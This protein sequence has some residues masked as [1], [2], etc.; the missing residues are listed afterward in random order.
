MFFGCE[1][2][3]KEYLLSTLL[4]TYSIANQPLIRARFYTN[5]EQD[6]KRSD[7]PSNQSI[8]QSNKH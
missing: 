2:T 6:S 8:N 1:S 4:L 7:D 5:I 3:F